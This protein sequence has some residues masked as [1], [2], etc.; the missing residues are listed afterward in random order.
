MSQIRLFQT[1]LISNW[2][3]QLLLFVLPISSWYADPMIEKLMA[4]DGYGAILN[5]ENPIL[6]QLPL[7]GFF[8]ASVGM[9]FFNNWA[10]YLY[11]ALWVYGW[12][13]TLL[14][15]FRVSVPAQGFIGM[16]IG[17]IDGMVLYVAFL[18]ALNLEFRRHPNPS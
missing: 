8:I 4:L 3:L 16:A 15:G 9:L 10:R 2:M 6:Y 11:L 12:I 1:L 18:S 13:A 14:F 7:W 5:W 17:T